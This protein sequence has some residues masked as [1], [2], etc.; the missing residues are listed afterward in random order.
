MS[1]SLARTPRTGEVIDS[2]QVYSLQ[3]QNLVE[4]T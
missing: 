1:V 2:T 3:N 4:V